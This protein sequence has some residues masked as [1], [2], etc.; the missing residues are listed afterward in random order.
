VLREKFAPWPVSIVHG[1]VAAIALILLIFGVIG[2]P[3]VSP[4]ALV[5]LALFV[6]AALGGF[7]LANLHRQQKLPPKALV[8][9]HASAAVIAFLL[10]LAAVLGF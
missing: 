2:N 8:L 6:L 1:F 5:A 3:S 10:L 4:L 9:T 7:Y